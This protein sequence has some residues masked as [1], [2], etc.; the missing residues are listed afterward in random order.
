MVDRWLI[1]IE[2][3]Y[4]LPQEQTLF[5]FQVPAGT[6]VEEA[7]AQCG[8]LERYQ[9]G[10][11]TPVGI[12]GKRVSPDTVLSSRDR[13]EIYRPLIADPKQARRRRAAKEKDEG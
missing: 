5:S 3:V 4:A 2:V 11:E 6:T 10:K 13:I 9:L 12:F 7:L 1:E 8:V